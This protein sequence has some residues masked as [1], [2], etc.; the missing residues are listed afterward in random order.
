METYECKHCNKTIAVEY[1]DDHNKSCSG[2]QKV[3]Y[4]KAPLKPLKHGWKQSPSNN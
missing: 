3:V 2:Q 1:R 4:K